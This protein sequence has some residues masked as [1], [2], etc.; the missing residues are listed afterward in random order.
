MGRMGRMGYMGCMGCMSDFCFVVARHLRMQTSLTKVRTH[1]IKMLQV[2]ER[3]EAS[4]GA[5]ANAHIMLPVLGLHDYTGHIPRGSAA[6]SNEAA[7]NESLPQ[8]CF[9]HCKN[10]A[11]RARNAV[12]EIGSPAVC[13]H[14][15]TDPLAA[16]C[17]EGM[18]Y[19]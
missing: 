7:W 9:L 12:L 10:I 16:F 3:F 6:G 15:G 1:V 13:F 4:A 8:W 5:A 18:C 11:S 19:E 14:K 17:Q 2:H